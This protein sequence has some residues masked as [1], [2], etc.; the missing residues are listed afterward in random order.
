MKPDMS[1]VLLS[2]SSQRKQSLSGMLAEYGWTAFACGEP[3]EAYRHVL[4]LFERRDAAPPL[5]VLTDVDPRSRT[6]VS[7]LR[8]LFPATGIMLVHGTGGE[9]GLAS[10]FQLGVDVWAPETASAELLVSMLLGLARRQ[11]V[12]QRREE[13]GPGSS[14]VASGNWTLG[15]QGWVLVSPEG[16]GMP[17]TTGER[18]FLSVLMS[19]PEKKASRETLIA[20]IHG[21]FE[22]SP[23]EKDRGRLGVMISRLRRKAEKYGLVLPLKSLRNWGYMF[24]GKV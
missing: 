9:P 8:T 11:A 6:V 21:E 12:W 16:V 13:P 10:C 18:A 22:E 23:S 1:V 15:D 7:S 19:A 24:S 5:F 3:A 17:L 14:S 2:A 4:Q 20:A